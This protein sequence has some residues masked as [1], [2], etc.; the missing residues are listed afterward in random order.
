MY[1]WWSSCIG[2]HIY[3]CVWIKEVLVFLVEYNII[4]MEKCCLFSL[5]FCVFLHIN[6]WSRCLTIYENTPDESQTNKFF[7]LSIRKLILC[8]LIIIKKKMHTV[9]KIFC[10]QCKKKL[11]FTRST[12]VKNKRIIFL[13][14]M[15]FFHI[16][17]LRQHGPFSHFS[18]FS[19]HIDVSFSW[20]FFATTENSVSD[21]L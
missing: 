21:S 20:L 1:W 4:L 17:K 15:N 5:S 11:N 3:I 10:F 16:T 6:N 12:D 2:C 7:L 13:R 8:A 19:L 18:P 9:F 14:A